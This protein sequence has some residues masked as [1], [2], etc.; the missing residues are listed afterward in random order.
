MDKINKCV[1]QCEQPSQLM[2]VDSQDQIP[3]KVRSKASRLAGFLYYK[4]ESDG[5]RKKVFKVLRIVWEV[6]AGLEFEIEEDGAGADKSDTSGDK[7]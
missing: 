4:T 2:I 6:E 1:N 3:Q 5:R 7:R